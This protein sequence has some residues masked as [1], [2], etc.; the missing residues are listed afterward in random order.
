MG[1]YSGDGFRALLLNFIDH[2]VRIERSSRCLLPLINSAVINPLF[3]G[4]TEQAKTVC[5][6]CVTLHFFF[7]SQIFPHSFILQAVREKVVAKCVTTKLTSVSTFR[8]F[9]FFTQNDHLKFTVTVDFY[10][11]YSAQI[12]LL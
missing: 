4:A 11:F 1:V 5:N 10:F 8:D 6:C 3:M 2:T 9:K 12:S 7:A